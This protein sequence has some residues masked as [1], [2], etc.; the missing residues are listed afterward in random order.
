MKWYILRVKIGDE[1]ATKDRILR[2][3]AD[4]E[5]KSDVGRLEIPMTEK[6]LPSDTIIKVKKVPVFTSTEI[7]AQI[8]GKAWETI[9]AFSGLYSYLYVEATMTPE[10]MEFIEGITGSRGFI[11]LSYGAKSEI[12]GKPGVEEIPTGI[13]VAL[14]PEEAEDLFNAL[15]EERDIVKQ[16]TEEERKIN[17]GDEVEVTSG[18]FKGYVGTVEEIKPN[19]TAK[20]IMQGS[21]NKEISVYLPITTLKVKA[22]LTWLNTCNKENSVGG[23]PLN[24]TCI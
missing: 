21:G 24:S 3:V 12:R 5:F 10:L 18:V 1:L 16:Q 2:A 19:Q 14:T 8:P 22:A 20:V 23:H 6:E 4:S 15:E 11:K 13:P 9:P 17:A 7:P